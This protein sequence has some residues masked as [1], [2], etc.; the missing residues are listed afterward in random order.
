MSIRNIPQL[1][2]IIKYL[3]TEKGARINLTGNK[4]T[5]IDA[6][7]SVLWTIDKV[8]SYPNISVCVYSLFLFQFFLTSYVIVK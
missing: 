4:T 2:V 3:K 8:S 7:S 6:I 5:L 1:K